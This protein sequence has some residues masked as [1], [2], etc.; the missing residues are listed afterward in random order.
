MGIMIF[1]DSIGEDFEIRHIVKI[2]RRKGGKRFYETNDGKWYAEGEFVDKKDFKF[3]GT[4]REGDFIATRIQDG[5]YF[6][7]TKSKF[8]QILLM[9]AQT[10]Y[11]YSK[12]TIPTKPLPKGL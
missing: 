6:I 8:N 11:D 5:M 7:V 1:T 2:S 4:P 10:S 12:Y 9:E 3:M